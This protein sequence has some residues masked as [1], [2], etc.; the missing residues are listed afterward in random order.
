MTITL[1]TVGILSW[2]WII[3]QIQVQ[4]EIHPASLPCHG[5]GRSVLYP[6]EVKE[7]TVRTSTQ[8][9]LRGIVFC[10]FFGTIMWAL[11]SRENQFNGLGSSTAKFD[12]Q[13]N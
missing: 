1:A 10:S 7:A 5:M 2:L 4:S 3:D 13:T 11:E 9:L 6:L 12:A 8:L